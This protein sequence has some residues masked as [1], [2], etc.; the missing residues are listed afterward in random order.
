M[1]NRTFPVWRDE[2]DQ[3][4]SWLSHPKY[5]SDIDG[6]R[7]VA[8]LGVVASH[9]F[10]R[11]LQGGFTGVDVFFVISGFLISSIIFESLDNGAFSFAEFYVRR[12]KRIFPALVLVIAATY[13][14]GWFVLLP[15]E[16][17]RLSK[18]IVA[19]VAFVS[20]IALWREAGYFDVS[21]A[22]KPLLHLWSLGIEEQFYLFWPALLWIA[23]KARFSRI[24]LIG[25][26][27]IVSFGLN[28]RG[29]DTDSTATFYSPLTRLWELSCGSLLAWCVMYPPRVFA[30]WSA[31]VGDDVWPALASAAG[32]ALLAA[33][34]V[35]IR[36]SAAYPGALALFPVGGAVLLIAAGQRAWINRA[37]LSNRVMVWFGLI[38]YPLYLWHWPLLAFARVVRGGEVSSELRLAAVGLAIGLAWL[39]YR[40]IETPIRFGG[41]GNRK[42]LALATTLATV[43]IVGFVTYRADGFGWRFP[44]IIQQLAAYQYDYRPDYREGSCFLEPAQN[45]AAFAKCDD[46]SLAQRPTLL[47]WGDSHAAH[48]YPGYKATYGAAM[49]VIQRTAAA[50][51]P[52][53]DPE[54]QLAEMAH[55]KEINDW[56]FAWIKENRPARVVLAARWTFYD[57]AK[58]DATVA[59]LRDLG[60]A[61]IELIGPVPQWNE[62]LP[63][64]LYA[65]FRANVPHVVPERLSSGLD[66]VF[67]ATDIAMR[68]K[69]KALGVT[70]I[71]PRD[72]MCDENGCMA[73]LGETGDALTAWD[74]AHLT[75]AGS[76]FLVGQFPKF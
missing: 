76:E 69:A 4:S 72:L 13:A 70:Y 17:R 31:K 23:W 20:N 61:R 48:L 5:R 66:P 22:T 38:S 56:I 34:Y 27:V 43:G 25:L 2:R 12:I 65:A 29:I 21:T 40:F 58:L 37:I 75:K 59:Q 44:A 51:P 73:R 57:A 1:Q 8:V 9:A 6:L 53:L 39:T 28:V 74:Y 14:V 26:T 63:R 55:C 16:F 42:A 3:S 50:C 49:N 46:G 68:E 15:D 45:S 71:S 10:P 19:G 47:L 7:A 18:H 60:I 32:V 36:Q 33:S 67:V 35:G 11:L 54:V 64:Q 41:Y 24:A 52:I 30:I 62:G